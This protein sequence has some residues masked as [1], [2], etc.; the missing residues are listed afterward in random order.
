MSDFM[1]RNFMFGML[2]VGFFFVLWPIMGGSLES[3]SPMLA[4]GFGGAFWASFDRSND[5]WGR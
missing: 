4:C 2:G 5:R 3:W 1:W